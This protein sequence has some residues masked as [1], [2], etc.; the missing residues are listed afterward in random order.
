MSPL[1]GC[2]ARRNIRTIAGA[3]CL[4]PSDAKSERQPPFRPLL[5]REATLTLRRIH[6]REERARERGLGPGFGTNLPIS[7]EIEGNIN[8][9][10]G[11]HKT[12]LANTDQPVVFTEN[13]KRFDRVTLEEAINAFAVAPVGWYVLLKNPARRSTHPEDRRH[14]QPVE[15]RSAA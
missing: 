14:Q 6:E 9:Y 11:P 1:H 12:S 13:T 10:V 15:L 5:D 8:V 3:G 7:D 4:R 2:A